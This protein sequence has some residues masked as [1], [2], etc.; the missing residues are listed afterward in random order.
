M[1][2]TS[3]I[4]T[5][6]IVSL[7]LNFRNKGLLKKNCLSDATTLA[8]KIEADLT[9]ILTFV[10]LKKKKHNHEARDKCTLDPKPTFKTECFFILLIL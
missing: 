3:I 7:R 8:E 9:L 10:C 1:E 4:I 6:R 5:L 2:L